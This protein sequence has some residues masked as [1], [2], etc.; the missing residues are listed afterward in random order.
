MNR[1]KFL[2]PILLLVCV[3]GC[4]QDQPGPISE[5]YPGIP[6]NQLVPTLQRIAE[7]GEYQSVLMNLTVGLEEVGFMDEAARIQEFS[8]LPEDKV[9][10]LAAEIAS[11]VRKAQGSGSGS[12]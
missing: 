7:T 10:Q 4:T 6:E 5:L 3:V 11:Q 1:M 2:I 9:K 12:G 8:G